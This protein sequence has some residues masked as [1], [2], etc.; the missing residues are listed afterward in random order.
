MGW[1]DAVEGKRGY[2]LLDG[3]EGVERD[4]VEHGIVEM[5]VY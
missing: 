1:T 4:F 2:E 5:V 3:V